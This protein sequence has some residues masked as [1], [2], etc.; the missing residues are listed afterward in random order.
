MSDNKSFLDS[1]AD[2]SEV[3]LEAEREYDKTAE[4]YWD[5][6]SNEQKLMAFYAVTKRIHKGELVDNGSY[7]YVLY[8]V[9][10]FGLESY[11]VGMSSGYMDLHNSIYNASDLEE[12]KQKNEHELIAR[13][14][15]VANSNTTKA[16][17]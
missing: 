4:S 14:L 6:L 7:R 10:G 5:S 16:N 1:L 3:F 2:L 13:T 8:D 17:V 12:L 11:S 9:F 15:S